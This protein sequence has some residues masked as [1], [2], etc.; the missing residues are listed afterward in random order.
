MALNDSSLGHVTAGVLIGSALHYGCN[1]GMRGLGGLKARPCTEEASLYQETFGCM[2]YF[3]THLAS[4]RN[5]ALRSGGSVSRQDFTATGVLSAR[6]R[7]LNTSPK[8]P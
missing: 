6:R 2:T 1:V 5:L 3:I 4:C 8:L 7:P